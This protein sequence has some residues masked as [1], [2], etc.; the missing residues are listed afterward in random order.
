MS[1]RQNRYP[2]GLLWRRDD[3][4]DCRLPCAIFTTVWLLALQL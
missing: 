4:R 3:A 2:S 1:L